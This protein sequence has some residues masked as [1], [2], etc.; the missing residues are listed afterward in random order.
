MPNQ[1]RISKRL[2]TREGLL[3]KQ[4]ILFEKDQ[5]RLVFHRP[6]GLEEVRN[7][8][9]WLLKNAENK[10]KIKSAAD[11][12]NEYVTDNSEKKLIHTIHFKDIAVI[13]TD[14][15][16]D[17]GSVGPKPAPMPI[18]NF[19]GVSTLNAIKLLQLPGIHGPKTPML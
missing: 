2:N 14:Y 15:P 17:K 18:I 10:G 8:I 11:I 3:N 16:P 5:I 1:L 4:N 9:V 7:G 6:P 12:A 13:I 19:V